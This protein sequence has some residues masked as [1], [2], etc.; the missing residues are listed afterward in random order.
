M[1]GGDSS[2]GDGGDGGGQ[3][4]EDHNNNMEPL[5]LEREA[6]RV[7]VCVW[8]GPWLFDES[9]IR[10]RGGTALQCSVF[11]GSWLRNCALG[12][13]SPHPMDLGV[14]GVGA[15]MN[16]RLV[17]DSCNI[18]DT[19]YFAGVGVRAHEDALVTLRGCAFRNNEF[20]VGVDGAARAGLTCS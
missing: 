5:L 3:G 10:C 20:A 1:G 9:E 8:G 16:A 13:L 11:G 17:M 18:S 15:Y 14:N 6:W 7:C 19:G 4:R 12:G 2:D